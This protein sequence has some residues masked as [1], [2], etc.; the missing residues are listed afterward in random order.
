MTEVRI[1]F[2][3]ASYNGALYIEEQLRSI[4][5]SLGP[6]DEI[7]VSDDGSSDATIERVEAIGDS[8]IHLLPRGER[9]GYQ[10]N[11]AR[12]IAASRGKY[13]FFSDQDDVCLPARVPQ[14]LAALEHSLCVCGDAIVVDA[15]LSLL[16]DSHFKTRGARFDLISLFVRPSVIGATIACQRGFIKSCLPFPQG[17]PHDMWIAVQATRYG[18]LAIVREP[19]ILYRRHP[20][21]VSNT[22]SAS[23]RSISVRIKERLRLLAAMAR[24]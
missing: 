21:V 8:R 23:S 19:F 20:S 3:V 16:Q 7:I 10:G 24:S 4:L 6:S 17:V 14:S 9:L 5:S 22:S 12:A 18:S 11:F 2:V 13:I 1:S 15:T